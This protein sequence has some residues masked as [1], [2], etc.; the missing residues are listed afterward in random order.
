[1]NKNIWP[2][3]KWTIIILFVIVYHA[4]FY[5]LVYEEC[6]PCER[7]AKYEYR[8]SYYQEI[9]Q[10]QYPKRKTSKRFDSEK[11]SII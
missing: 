5:Y 1:M 9:N 11:S 8:K 4:T 3:L 2:F 7:C 10:R 6:E